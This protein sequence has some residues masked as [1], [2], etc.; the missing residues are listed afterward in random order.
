M[1]GCVGYLA[2]NCFDA[3]PPARQPACACGRLCE[4]CRNSG[5]L[6][7]ETCADGR[8]RPCG[9]I[10]SL[11][12]SFMSLP[13]TQHLFCC[14]PS[15]VVGARHM[16]STANTRAWPQ[17]RLGRGSCCFFW[18]G[19]RQFWCLTLLPASPDTVCLLSV[20]VS[21]DDRFKYSDLVLGDPK[22]RAYAG[23]PL[24][25]QRDGKTHKLGTLCVI[26][27]TPRT[28]TSDQISLLE[29]MAKLVV[30]EI[31]IRE[32]AIRGNG[33]GGAVKVHLFPRRKNGDQWPP[34]KG[35]LPIKVDRQTVESMFAMPQPEAARALGISK[36]FL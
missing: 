9:L 14:W 34:E 12:D 24:L 19:V 7:H 13:C 20:I 30:A 3:P 21:Q 10:A 31:E 17:S 27:A 32:K 36:T 22:I 18:G 33:G 28:V 4:R 16:L 8:R 15:P 1:H 2:G 11:R 5:G 35:R 26:D 25:Y 29:T 23:V 6:L